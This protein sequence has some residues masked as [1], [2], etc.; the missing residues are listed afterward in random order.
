MFMDNFFDK[1][2]NIIGNNIINTG[3]HDNSPRFETI[4]LGELLTDEFIG[5]STDFLNFDHMIA[6]S[7]F[8]SEENTYNDLFNSKEW[9]EFVNRTTKFNNWDEMVIEAV[10]NYII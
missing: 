2:R 10:K 9:N 7:G 3:K 4:T 8:K 5:K 6:L 1:I